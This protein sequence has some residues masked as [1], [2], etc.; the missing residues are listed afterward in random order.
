MCR[1]INIIRPKSTFGRPFFLGVLVL[2][3]TACSTSYQVVLDELTPMPDDSSFA[4]EGAR[5]HS[6]I[7]TAFVPRVTANNVVDTDPIVVLTSNPDA[8]EV[9]S[10]PVAFAGDGGTNTTEGWWIVWAV[11]PGSAVVTV[12]A[13]SNTVASIPVFV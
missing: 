13:G 3:S 1:M 9:A 10:V 11:A 8:V 5:L 4:V 6:G 7:A 12:R 2:V